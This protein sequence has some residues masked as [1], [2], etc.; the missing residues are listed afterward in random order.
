MLD[1]SLCVPQKWISRT[2]WVKNL[3]P[4]IHSFPL[5]F[6]ENSQWKVAAIYEAKKMVFISQWESLGSILYVIFPCFRFKSIT[7]Q[8]EDHIAG[9]INGRNKAPFTAVGSGRYGDVQALLVIS[10][11]FFS[12]LQEWNSFYSSYYISYYTQREEILIKWSSY[13]FP[14]N[15]C[16][17][18][19][20][21]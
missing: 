18:M 6:L 7:F 8:Q 15:S 4:D 14:L 11:A 10:V 21:S 12:Y 16:L 9:D 19:T 5:E 13:L 3:N 20:E 2:L 1:C 17:G